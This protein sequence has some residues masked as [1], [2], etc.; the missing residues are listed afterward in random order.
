MSR[1]SRQRRRVAKVAVR[2]AMEQHAQAVALRA[3]PDNANDKPAMRSG[4]D[5]M[6]NP[7]TGG[8]AGWN[9]II[10]WDPWL[11]DNPDE[12]AKARGGIY[13]YQEMDKNPHV[14]AATTRLIGE[15]LGQSWDIIAASD[16]PKDVEIA[17][18]VRWVLDPKGFD[19]I[20]VLWQ[21]MDCIKVGYSIT[22]KVWGA[23]PDGPWAG[24]WTIRDFKSKDPNDYR[25]LVD[26]FRNVVGIAPRWT[27][28]G[29]LMYPPDMVVLFSWMPRYN[30]P[31]G[32][33]QYKKALARY[34]FLVYTDKQ[35]I[36]YVEQYGNPTKI[37]KVANSANK[38]AM[39]T[40]L[41]TVGDR[42]A[43]AIDAD[44]SIEFAKPAAGGD[45][46]LAIKQ[47][48]AQE[49]AIAILGSHLMIM[50]G[51]TQGSR[52]ASETHAESASIPVN[53]IW[54]LIGANIG[55]QVI[56]P[57]VRM[58]FGNV[59]KFPRIERVFDKEME[60]TT[61][62]AM[63]QFME[64]ILLAM[65]SGITVGQDW[66]RDLFGIP[67]PIEGEETLTAPAEPA[68]A[69]PGGSPF[70]GG[71]EEEEG[72]E[73]VDPEDVE[74]PAAKKKATPKERA[75]MAARQLEDS[76]GIKPAINPP[77]AVG[78]AARRVVKVTAEAEVASHAA[79]KRTINA[80]RSKVLADLKKKRAP[81]S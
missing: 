18:F 68:P 31:Y 1:A 13:S 50:E 6:P 30:N 37:G 16:D 64:I 62:L 52:A 33:A 9:S 21:C 75:E 39:L 41:E 32:E 58:N 19:F 67:V 36:K 77:G 54:I 22:E 29:G 15:A 63:R 74:D 4:G 49:I 24:K 60:Y 43:I 42:T 45:D 7:L 3:L 70:G 34:E 28:S 65:K 76:L 27:G 10:G 69:F 80:F 8:R 57:L 20:R 5:K 78:A 59:E 38:P 55:K 71:D 25:I 66:F 2:Q 17:D 46:L 44:E 11:S 26:A 73:D 79:F 47:Q 81:R 48:W 61:L 72:D 35:L 53:L 23:V 40:A 14:S 51:G 56:E 12:V